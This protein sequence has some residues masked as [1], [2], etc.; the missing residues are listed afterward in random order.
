MSWSTENSFDALEH[1]LRTDWVHSVVVRRIEIFMW[2]WNNQ[3]WFC[4]FDYLSWSC[5]LNRLLDI[6]PNVCSVVSVEIDNLFHQKLR[7]FHV[8]KVIIFTECCDDVKI[9]RVG[10][11]TNNID[12][13]AHVDVVFGHVVF[14]VW[15]QDSIIRNLFELN[16]DWFCWHLSKFFVMDFWC[17]TSSFRKTLNFWIKCVCLDILIKS[18][19]EILLTRCTEETWKS[20]FSHTWKADWYEENFSNVWHFTLAEILEQILV[21]LIFQLI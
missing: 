12:G 5:F 20:W 6:W 1:H 17:K 13:S 10:F 2:L 16:F 18:L 4:R 15:G 21:Q 3:H 11:C 8:F 7:A 9:F 19:V 14:S